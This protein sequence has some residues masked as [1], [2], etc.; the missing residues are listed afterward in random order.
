MDDE[1]T[2]FVVNSSIKETLAEIAAC[3]RKKKIFKNYSAELAVAIN[4]NSPF[5]SSFKLICLA[6]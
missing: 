5:P 1:H 6:I 4:D 3:F 2:L